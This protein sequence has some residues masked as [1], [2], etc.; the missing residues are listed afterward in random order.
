MRL[1]NAK[2]EIMSIDK[3]DYL[4]INSDLDEAVENVTR[5]IETEELKVKRNLE[6]INK[7]KE[8]IDG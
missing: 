3:F 8:D 7:L 1:L 4:V 5:I 2:E 6:I